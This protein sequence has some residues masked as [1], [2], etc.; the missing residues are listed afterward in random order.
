MY[1]TNSMCV[2][3]EWMYIMLKDRLLLKSCICFHAI[4][5]SYWAPDLAEHTAESHFIPQ[6]IDA[7]MEKVGKLKGNID[8]IR[9]KSWLPLSENPDF[10]P[11]TVKPGDVFKDAH[12]RPGLRLANF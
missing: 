12:F 10:H 3:V 11:T 6:A 7:T 9:Y 5:V 4:P 2:K 8:T 1:T